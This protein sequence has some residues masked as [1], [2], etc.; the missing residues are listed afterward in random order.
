[1][2]LLLARTLCSGLALIGT[3]CLDP[4]AMALGYSILQNLDGGNHA[5]I[6]LLDRGRVFVALSILAHG[7]G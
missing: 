1:M 7:F 4:V 6:A 3:I 2:A 5:S